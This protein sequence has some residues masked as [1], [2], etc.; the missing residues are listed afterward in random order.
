MYSCIFSESNNS[1]ASPS[2]LIHIREFISGLNKAGSLISMLENKK[3]NSTSLFVLLLE[4]HSYQEFFT[5]ITS[6][7]NFKDAVRNLLYLY[8]NLVKSKF[9]KSALKKINGKSNNR[10]REINLQQT[11]CDNQVH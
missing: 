2:D 3:I 4:N 7:I 11:S 6:S 8:P 1:N 9:T 10:I 5:E